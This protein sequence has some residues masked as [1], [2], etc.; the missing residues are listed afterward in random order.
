[1]LAEL[2][3]IPVGQEP[4]PLHRMNGRESTPPARHQRQ[5][6][7][8]GKLARR[9][10]GDRFAVLNAFVDAG[11]AGLSRVEIATWFV[12]YRDVRNGTACVSEESIAVRI[13]CSVRA[14]TNAL[15]ALRNRGQVLQVFRGGQDRGPSRYRVHPLPHP[16]KPCR[17]PLP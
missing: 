1:M 3:P 16:P 2:K 11:M 6:Q 5:K 12:L 14:V 4:P 9:K 15:R 10:T 13:G 8:K 7:A 17:S